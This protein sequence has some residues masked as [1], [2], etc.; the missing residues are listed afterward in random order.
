M[1]GDARYPSDSVVRLVLTIEGER[2]N[3]NFYR[4]CAHQVFAGFSTAGLALLVVL[5]WTASATAQDRGA[6]SEVNPAAYQ[7][8]DYHMIGPYRGGRVTAVAGV[9]GRPQTFYM[10]GT[11][12]GVWK[13]ESAGQRWRNVTDGE[14]RAGSIGQIEV[15]NSDPSVVYIGTGSACIRGNVSTGRGLYKSV[16]GGR[17]WTF[18][19]LPEAGQI[20]EIAVHPRNPELVYVAALGHPF[21]ENEQRGVFRSEDGGRSWEKVLF[22]ND[23]TGAVDLSM[24]P[25]RPDELYAAAWSAERKPW[26]I[27]SGTRW[28]DGAGIWKT[29]DGGESW[30]HLSKGLP[31]GDTLVGKIGVDVS[32]ADPDRVYAIVEAEAGRSGIFRSDDAGTTWTRVNADSTY[33]QRPFYYHHVDAHPTD[34]NTIFLNGEQLWKSVDGGRSYV[35]VETPHGDNHDMWINPKHPRIMVQGND[36]GANV[37]L[38]GGKEW[39][40]QLNQPTAEM[41][42]VEVD[43][44]V[45]YR[46]YGPQQD[47]STITVYSRAPGGEETNPKQYWYAVGGCET[48]PIE[49]R[50]ENAGVVYSGCYNGRIT[51][52]NR[53]T[54]QI[55]QIRNYPQMGNGMPVRKLK[56]R[57]QWNAPILIS[58]HGPNVVYHGSQY[59]H[60]TTNGG[61]SWEVISPDLTKNDTT[62]QGM[63]GGPITHDITGVE[64]Y[65]TTLSM[66][67][68]PL[69]QGILWVGTNDGLIHVSRDGGKTWTEVTPDGLPQPASVNRIDPSHHAEGTVYVAAYRYRLDD[70]QPYIYKTEDYGQSWTRLTTGKNGIP[71]D[72]PTRVVREDPQQPGLLYAGTEFGLFVSF[73]D[74]QRWQELQLDLPVTPVTDLAVHRGDLV[75]STQ[76]RSFWVLNDLAPLRQLA[77]QDVGGQPH[78]FEPA[79]EYRLRGGEAEGDAVPDRPPHGVAIDYYLPE[80]SSS[81]VTV[82]VLESD[83]D[84]VERYSSSPDSADPAPAKVGHNRLIWDFR[85]TDPD[86]VVRP[87]GAGYTDVVGPLAVPDTY[88]IHV[89][90]GNWSQ[91]RGFRLK[92]DP[93]LQRDGVTREDLRA[94]FDL[95][96]QMWDRLEEGDSAVARIRSV[97]SQLQSLSKHLREIPDADDLR[98][99]AQSLSERLTA[100]ENDLVRTIPGSPF[101]HEPQWHNHLALLATY[102][103]SADA[104]PTQQSRERFKDLE[105]ELER[106][107]SDLR[108]IFEEVAALNKR[109]RS[110]N[111]SH[112]IVPG[113]VS[114]R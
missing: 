32:P 45:P 105:A 56:Y 113:Q 110:R 46:V 60:R 19:G 64:V 62:K 1:P 23:S 109:L 96:V 103:A 87:P 98:T 11:G 50:P 58:P 26:T 18:I 111:V 53:R 9:S 37:T 31:S 28:T 2:R 81:Q 79:D 5:M 108:S 73:D 43:N 80:S 12:G 78:L 77:Q 74:G 15:A 104:R 47:N 67:E 89:Q 21:G 66:A 70:W 76:G 83:G 75:V 55:Q 72:Y 101:S 34:P 8:L 100:V 4:W 35:E 7:A 114:E 39:S 65:P 63:A 13:T 54:R 90:R 88:R 112:V 44:R 57:I 33:L 14:L 40:T 51:R 106:H 92:I 10:G 22:L 6:Q 17:S 16:D 27:R 71:S 85:Y 49:V 29:T 36:G 30:S 94:Q 41:Y 38:N 91:T 107:R 99:E 97:R 86:T 24:N 69:Q 25:E 68:S 20:G 61:H 52:Y 42:S 82:E 59:V 84:L 3:M 93:R 95:L 48:G 102:V